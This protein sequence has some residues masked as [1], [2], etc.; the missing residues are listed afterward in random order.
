MKNIK[1]KLLKI[2][3][4]LL[5]SILPKITLAEKNY[6]FNWDEGIEH[7]FPGWTWSDDVNGY[8]A[9]GWT[10]NSGNTTY[11]PG[12]GGE[13]FFWGY[14]PRFFKKGGDTGGALVSIDADNRAPSTITGGSLYVYDDSEDLL[15]YPGWWVLYDGKNLKTRG[16]T[17]SATDRMSFYIQLEGIS[18]NSST[19]VGDVFHVGTYLCEGS[20]GIE[21][22]VACPF[23][24]PGNQHYYHYL[25]LSPD[26]WIHVNLDQH[27]TH[28]RDSSVADND[29]SFIDGTL[30]QHY[31]E[32]LHQFYMEV[33]YDTG[34]PDTSWHLDEMYFYSTS[35]LEESVE[36]DQND[37]SITSLWVGYWPTTGKWQ[38]GWQDE[39]YET[40][41]GENTN[42]Y[43]NSTF[44]IKYSTSPITNE[45]WDL[46]TYV[47]PEWFGYPNATSNPNGVRRADP[48]WARAWTQ[49]EIPSEII[50]NNNKI[51]FAIKDVSVG[52][53][54][55]GSTYP[56]NRIDGHDAP[57]SD[58]HLID[59]SIRTTS[60][61]VAPNSPTGLSIL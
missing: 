48:W 47:S 27:P 46:A 8:G 55:A 33:R 40:A 13:N 12:Y 52:G 28:R 49:F 53:A 32:D 19:Q 39:S 6:L 45:N 18:G 36:S 41:S 34:D 14:G 9:P 31:F 23:E 51:Y 21:Q 20:G 44:E 57:S 29:P 35:D 17:D 7:T 2:F 43:T 3:I 5:V 15:Y 42:D 58:V 38:M 11:L 54:G 22:G 10:L 1:N 25:Y 30:T 16:L 60:E 50:E 56:W 24:G 26:A 4:L 61:L 59:Y 37:D